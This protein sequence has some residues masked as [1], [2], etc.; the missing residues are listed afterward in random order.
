MQYFSL[1]VALAVGLLLAG[2]K[3]PT[4]AIVQTEG[5]LITTVDTGMKTWD[6]YVTVHQNDGKVTQAEVNAV[7][8]AYNTYYYAQEMSKAALESYI[9]NNTTNS[10]AILTA[11]QSVVTA[12]TALLSLLN[13]YIK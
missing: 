1:I 6:M 3:S 11:N 2:C 9:A 5:V 8:S 10:A 7:H 4:T 13:Q 12:E